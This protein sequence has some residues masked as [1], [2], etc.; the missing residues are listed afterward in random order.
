MIASRC[1]WWMKIWCFI[2]TRAAHCGRL[3]WHRQ[4]VPSHRVSFKRCG[5]FFG[6][7]R[8]RYCHLLKLDQRVA[9]DWSQPIRLP[10]RLRRHFS[11]AN[12]QITRTGY[13]FGNCDLLL[14]G[15]GMSERHQTTTWG[16]APLQLLLPLACYCMHVRVFFWVSTNA[17]IRT[18]L[19]LQYLRGAKMRTPWRSWHRWNLQELI[20]SKTP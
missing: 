9:A 7:A 3:P 5:F 20:V 10:P 11:P 17:D 1:S 16:K 8:S 18:I 19:F 6:R 12:Q 15:Q 14:F 4:R 13:L 2:A